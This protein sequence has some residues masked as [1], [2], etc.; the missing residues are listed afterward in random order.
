[1][2]ER[3]THTRLGLM[4][5][6]SAL[7]SFALAAGAFFALNAA[8]D[9][10]I[11]SVIFTKEKIVQHEKE[12]ILELID[13]MN[14][15]RFTLSDHK[16][17][18][19]WTEGKSNLMLA[20]YDASMLY[21][22]TGGDARL[23]SGVADALTLYD[24]LQNEYADYWY[25]C[26]VSSGGDTV[27]SRA[28]KVMY[29][30]MYKARNLA[31]FAEA[32]LAF[33]IFV[34][35]LLLMI[36]RKTRY[37]GILSRQLQRMQ[38]GDLSQP[39]T[40]RGRDELTSLAEDMEEM[41]KSFIER[42]ESEEKM[43]KNASELLTAMSHDLR[44]PLTALIGYLDIVDLGKCA[45]GEQ[46]KRY[47]HS[48]RLKAYQIKEMTDKLFEYFLVYSSEEKELETESLDAATLFL[49]LWSESALILETD[50]FTVDVLE[51]LGTGEVKAN[52]AFLRRVMDNLV[53]NIRK[54]ADKAISVT[55]TMGREGADFYFQV[56]NA[57][58]PETPRAE[59][60]GIGLASCRKIMESHSG[61][62]ESGR[63]GEVY[64]S[65]LLLP[66]SDELDMITE[67]EKETV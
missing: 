24:L 15:E 12:L 29:F 32:A 53:S 55:V 40:I 21:F 52:V 8:G 33:L 43:T 38:G 16:N 4:L 18:Q 23:Y 54:Y 6:L 61:S 28:V 11:D 67:D 51:P 27:R 44:T 56:E 62:F 63:R 9:R 10:L 42:L 7:L 60:S 13:E 41:R 50:G 37:I 34:F 65:R 58:A 39:M 59:S 48:G 35:S 20:V 30:P 2:T 14:R 47:V 22:Q 57:V 64:V 49:Q 66:A 36:Q 31:L 45:D 46:E 26:L 5:V 19:A 1:M 3:R 25:S 17:V